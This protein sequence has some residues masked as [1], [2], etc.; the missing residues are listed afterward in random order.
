MKATVFVLLMILGGM[1]LH[2]QST[3]QENFPTVFLM[4]QD[5]TLY[6]QLKQ[7]YTYSLLDASK[8]DMSMAFDAWLKFMVAFEEYANSQNVDINGAKMWIHTFFSKE[9]NV[10]HIGFLLKDD[11]RNVDISELT[12]AFKGFAGQYQ[13]PLSFNSPFYNYTGATFPT[14]AKKEK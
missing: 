12:A 13:L 3:D 5:E 10:D 6:E 2:A 8:D 7:K 1:G 11:S 4:G 9:G 14:F